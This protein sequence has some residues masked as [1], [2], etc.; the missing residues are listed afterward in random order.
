MN[1]KHI[2]VFVLLALCSAFSIFWGMI[3]EH[4]ARGRI[5]DF[6]LA[7]YDT[8][9]LLRGC[10]PYS[11]DEM[12]NVYAAEG[13][14][15]PSDP[16]QR[17]LI[18]KSMPSQV[19][20]PTAFLFIAPFALLGWPVAHALWMGITAIAFTLA[21]F[22]IFRVGAKHSADVSFGL[23]AFMLLNCGVLFA[24]GNAA[25][26]AISLCVVAVWTFVEG[27]LVLLGIL[28]LGASLAI[29]P[30]DSGLIWLY[31]LL[32]GTV[33]RK[34]ALQSLIVVA[35]LSVPAVIWIHQVAPNW[36][37]EVQTNLLATST[38]GGNADPG[39][40]SGMRLGPGMIIDLQTAISVF[41]DDP[42]IYNIATYAVCGPLLLIWAFW[43]IRQAASTKGTWLALAAISALSLVPIYHRPYDAKLL[44]L[45]IPACAALWARGGLF[46]RL[47]LVLT[48][49]GI[50]AT[51]DIPL[52]VG[53]V[54]TENLH[55]SMGSLPDKV[56]AVLLARF[57][58]LAL[59]AS[60]TFYLWVYVRGYA[61]HSRK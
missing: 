5:A 8:R 32:S 38:D 37:H 50:V 61:E 42:R 33:H 26:M 11:A 36:I 18:A 23:I 57:I 10:D 53:Y 35:V 17:R 16:G 40:S 31:F 47:A 6:K 43:V 4:S 30:H 54:L 1:K 45:T 19:Y 56:A 28:C 12:W 51:S 21:S 15:V 60:G 44:L 49:V 46:G 52:A 55:L 9:C 22:L 2:M 25:G 3:A 29:K 59:L 14:K 27:R 24:G 20:L 39:P 7:Y 58:P 13:N 34:R 41:R 48:S